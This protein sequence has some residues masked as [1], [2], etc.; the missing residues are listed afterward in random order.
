M[1]KKQSLTQDSLFDD[2]AS[3]CSGGSSKESAIYLDIPLPNSTSSAAGRSEYHTPDVHHNSNIHTTN[4]NTFLFAPAPK[5]TKEKF[6]AYNDECWEH[7]LQRHQIGAKNDGPHILYPKPP[8]SPPP[9]RRRIPLE[10]TPFPSPPPLN[11]PSSTTTNSSNPTTNRPSSSSSST[12][13]MKPSTAA[14]KGKAPV[15]NK[16]NSKNGNGKKRSEIEHPELRQLMNEYDEYVSTSAS[17]NKKTP[18]MTQELTNCPGF[19]K[20]DQA[21][22]KKKQKTPSNKSSSKSSVCA[23]ATN[24]RKATVDL[25]QE[26]DED[27]DDDFV[28][29]KRPRSKK[30]VVIQEDIPHVNQKNSSGA[31][32][33]KPKAGTA[34]SFKSTNKGS[35]S[36]TSKTEATKPP[37]GFKVA[38]PGQ[39]CAGCGKTAKLCHQRL[40]GPFAINAVHNYTNR[41]GTGVTIEGIEQAFIRGYNTGLHYQE[42]TLNKNNIDETTTFEPTACVYRT[43]FYEAVEHYTDLLK[44]QAVLRV[45]E[46]IHKEMDMFE[47]E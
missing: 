44:E 1:A 19:T 7:H 46:V 4:E 29:P 2:E 11:K 26:K 25:S 6:D 8:Q 16:K 10:N 20:V 31:A 34:K 28:K 17:T 42:W 40:Y 45:E 39:V 35:N 36:K 33:S 32:A 43:S 22:L 13:L 38:K 15:V 18:P 24:K 12:K 37:K 47:L 30:K 9:H 23:S 14:R 3:S 21:A 41:A 5:T 27:S